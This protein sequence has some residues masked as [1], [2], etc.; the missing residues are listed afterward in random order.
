M[1]HKI[2]NRLFYSDLRDKEP[3][4]VDRSVDAILSCANE[5]MDNSLIIFTIVSS[6]MK[7][8]AP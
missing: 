7:L 5:Y 3:E 8:S 4:A 2:C 1:T 6:L